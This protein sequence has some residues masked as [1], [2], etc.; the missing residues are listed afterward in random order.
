MMQVGIVTTG[1]KRFMLSVLLAMMLG[2]VGNAFAGDVQ[3][4]LGFVAKVLPGEE[5]TASTEIWEGKKKIATIPYAS[6][7][8]FSPD[9]RVLLLHEAEASDDTRHFLLNI[10]GGEYIK[11]QKDRLKW[12]VGNRYVVKTGWT[13]DS[14][15][16]VL[17]EGLFP[18]KSKPI[19]YTV[20]KYITPAKS[21]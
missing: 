1:K 5:G 8:S 19:R 15:Y 16:V 4:K 3:S 13:K 14:K 6:A 17:H 12:I 2:A 20:A 10:A 9:G 11:N 18:E 21:K 7:I